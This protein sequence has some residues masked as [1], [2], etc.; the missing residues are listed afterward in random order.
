M[1]V[2]EYILIA[3]ALLA[4]GLGASLMARRLRLPSL[5]LFLGLGMA[6]GSDGAGWIEFND[7]ELARGIGVIA[8]S[9]ILFEGGLSAGFAEIRPVLR[10]AIGLALLGTLATAVITG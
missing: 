2:D 10:P 7:Y 4:G 9:L 5:L 1:H 6:V 8:L 3:S